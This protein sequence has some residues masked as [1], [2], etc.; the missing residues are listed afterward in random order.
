[1]KAAAEDGIELYVGVQDLSGTYGG[2]K[3][4]AGSSNVYYAA[5]TIKMAIVIALMQDIEAGKYALEQTVQVKPE[6]VVGGAGSLKDGKF[7]Q[8]IT[9][10]RLAG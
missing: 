5:S 10:E 7:P 1:M 6:Q 9:I 3:L 2:G 4:Q 8:E